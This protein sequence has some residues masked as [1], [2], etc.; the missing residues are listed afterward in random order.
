MKKVIYPLTFLFFIF[1]NNPYLKILCT[2]SFLL[3][4]LVL[5]KKVRIIPNILLIFTLTVLEQFTP[6]GLVVYEIG[7]FN[8]TKG[9]LES[10]LFKSSL[11][12]GTIYLSKI[13]TTG[14]I[15]L[16]GKVG[17][18]IGDIFSYFNQLTHGEKIWGSNVIE[19]LDSKL[20]N[21]S[22]DSKKIESTKEKTPTHIIPFIIS[23]ILLALDIIII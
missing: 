5:S 18:L 12:I 13:I 15:I 16:P 4:N 1:I 21:L 14:T 7:V 20:L 3:M 8:I 10:G 11:L 22:K 6:R 17:I 23:L 19:D 2:I 9:A